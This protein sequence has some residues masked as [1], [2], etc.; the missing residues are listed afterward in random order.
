[1]YCSRRTRS[2]DAYGQSC[3][4]LAA[5]LPIPPARSP[6]GDVQGIEIRPQNPDDAGVPVH[7]FHCIPGQVAGVAVNAAHDA[8]QQ[9]RALPGAAVV[10]EHGAD[11]TA[12]D[13]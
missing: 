4:V 3:E 9:P 10:A 11:V 7:G 13:Y 8:A 12:V 1:M 5:A 6:G 2:S